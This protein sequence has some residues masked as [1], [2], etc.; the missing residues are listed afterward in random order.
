[1]KGT[2]HCGAVVL[3]VALSDGLTTAR[4]CDCSFCRLRAPLR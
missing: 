3:E 2:C 1:M 4:R